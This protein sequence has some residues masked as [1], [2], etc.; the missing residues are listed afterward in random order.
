MLAEIGEHGVDELGG[1]RGHEHLAA[2]ASGCDPR[3]AVDVVADV[4][5][6]AEKR[7]ARVDADADADPPARGQPLG[8]GRAGPEPWSRAPR[9]RRRW[10]KLPASA[11][12]CGMTLA[13]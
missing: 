7:R 3:G 10:T 11:S 9:C 13:Q 12:A 5:L 8:A 6:V 4:A 2:V 1:R